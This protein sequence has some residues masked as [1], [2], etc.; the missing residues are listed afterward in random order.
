MRRF[1]ALALVATACSSGPTVPRAQL[2]AWLRD[3][4]ASLATV[5]D[6]SCASLPARKGA[7]ATCSITF[8][9]GSK[10]PVRERAFRR[11]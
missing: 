2:V 1:L 3:F 11:G 7:T 9:D 4:G 10:W 5:R 6:A 8:D